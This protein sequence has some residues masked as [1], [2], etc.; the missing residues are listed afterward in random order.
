MGQQKKNESMQKRGQWDCG[1]S[2]PEETIQFICNKKEM[3]F[4]P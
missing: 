2:K 3:G 1:P 4:A